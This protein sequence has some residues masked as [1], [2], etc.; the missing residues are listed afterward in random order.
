MIGYD[1]LVAAGSIAAARAKGLLRIEG[2][3]YEVREGDILNI[4]F[5][6]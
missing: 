1:K 6:V 3:A 2:K 4:R 5:A